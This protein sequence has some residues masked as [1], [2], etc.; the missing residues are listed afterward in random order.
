VAEFIAGTTTGL[1]V[2]VTTTAF[3]SIIVVLAWL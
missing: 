3:C 1:F 2:L